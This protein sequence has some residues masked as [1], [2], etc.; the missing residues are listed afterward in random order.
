MD[1]WDTSHTVRIHPLLLV[2]LRRPSL[3]RRTRSHTRRTSRYIARLL[4]LF[5]FCGSCVARGAQGAAYDAHALH[6]RKK[7]SAWLREQLCQIA[8]LSDIITKNKV[9]VTKSEMNSSFT[10]MYIARSNLLQIH[11]GTDHYRLAAL[12]FRK[13]LSNRGWI[14]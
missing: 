5:T 9:C 4:L 7:R 12:G 13:E 6:M 1:R 8:I 2:T 11:A 3:Y 14:S 10:D